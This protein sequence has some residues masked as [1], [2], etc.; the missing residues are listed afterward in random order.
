MC[1]RS[2]VKFVVDDWPEALYV[3]ACASIECVS[4]GAIGER[5]FDSVVASAAD[6]ADASRQTLLFARSFRSS[7]TRS[8]QNPM[9]VAFQSRIHKN[10]VLD[11]LRLQDRAARPLQVAYR[12]SQS[13]R[14]PRPFF[15]RNIEEQATSVHP[16]VSGSPLPLPHDRCGR[17]RQEDGLVRR[18]QGR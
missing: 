10:F 16:Q 13:C 17:R 7:K 15:S 8:T 1:A 14:E 4:S 9:R 3:S 12:G 18:R 2:C 11:V 5:R 6:A